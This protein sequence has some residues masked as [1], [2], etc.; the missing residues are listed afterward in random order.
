MKDRKAPRKKEHLDP[1]SEAW[2]HLPWRK[3]EKHV[4]RIQ[5]RIFRAEQAGKTQVVHKLQKLL[6]KSEAARLIAVRRVTQENQGKKTAGVDGVKSLKPAER[7]EMAS[8]LHPKQWKRAMQPV[9]RIYIP[10]PGKTE[11]RPLG[12]PTMYERARQSLVKIVLEPEWEAKFEPNSYGFRPGRSCH[13]AIEAIFT[14]IRS[15]HKYVLDADIAGCF[16]NIDHDQLLQK[17]QTTPAI[18]AMIKQ[19]LKAGAL[20]ENA[21]L[22]TERGTPQGGT[23]SPLLANIAL[24]GMEALLKKSFKYTEGEP[25]FVRYADDFLVFHDTQEGIEKAKK[26]IEDWLQKRGLTLKESKTRITNTKEEFEF[27]GFSIRQ[28]PVGKTHTGKTPHG[29]PLGFKTIIKPSKEATARHLQA[30]AEK[31]KQLRAAPQ[32]QLIHALNPI[33]RGWANYYRGVVSK[34]VYSR[35]DNQIYLLLTQWAEHRHRKKSATW[36]DRKYWT[37]EPNKRHSFETDKVTL[38]RHSDTPIQRHV[39]VRGMASPYDGNLLYWSKRLKNHPM[40]KNGLARLLQKQDGK[41]KWC[42]LVFKDGDHIEVDHIQPISMGGA[43]HLEN[44]CALHLHCHDQRH[45]IHEKDSITEEPCASK[46]ARTVLKTSIGGDF[47][48]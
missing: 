12:I 10:K 21:F 19:W 25:Y 20:D 23:L 37:R 7:L 35:C 27:L 41:C 33:I 2:E 38:R 8:Q 46:E 39:K 3:L 5:K 13:D 4:Y 6:L 43:D 31:C 30:I 14:T 18:R 48:A 34:E 1:E 16:D 32:E 47:Y 15:K 24:D 26:L 40:T 29:K 11:K 36:Q 44:K 22:Q 42:G 17:L 9:R 28:F 45:S